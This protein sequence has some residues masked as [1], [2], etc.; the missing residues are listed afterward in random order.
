M[1]QEH[2]DA[3]GTYLGFDRQPHVAEGW[4][5]HSDMSLW[6]TYRTAHPLYTLLYPEAARDFARSLLAMAEE[7]GAFPRWPAALG[8]G[9]SMIGAPADIVMADTYLRGVTDIRMDDAWPRLRAQSLGEVDAGYNGRTGTSEI[10]SLGWIPSDV[11]GGSVA[12][13]Q[14]LNWAD[15][16]MAALAG[17]LGETADA[18][19]FA[20]RARTFANQ[21]DPAVGFFHGRRADGS[22]EPAPDPFAWEDEYVEGN[23]WQYLWMPFPEWA[24]LREVLGGPDAARARLDTFFEEAEREGVMDFPQTWYWHGNEPDIHAPWLF[25]LWGDADSTWRWIRWVADTHYAADPVGLAGNDDGGTLSAW[26]LFAGMG[27]YPIAGSDLW[28]VSPPL[29]PVADMPVAGGRFTVR[30]EGEGERVRGATLDGRTLALPLLHHAELS[31]GSELVVTL[32]E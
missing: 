4:T 23:A 10:D 32:G 7:G 8:D 19:F 2:G 26:Y 18:A 25:T 30:R 21:Y 11:H 24:S 31:A 6:D 22:F 5:Y 16:A 28:V 27:L 12:W 14:E 9:G 13:Q 20:A 17:A 29:F 1:P 15:G 3:D